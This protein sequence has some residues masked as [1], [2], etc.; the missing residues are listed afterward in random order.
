[1]ASRARAALGSG[2]G[3]RDATK[4][5]QFAMGAGLFVMMIVLAVGLGEHRRRGR[6]RRT[7]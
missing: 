5:M 4:P 7:A 3:R 1:M 6:A 2:A